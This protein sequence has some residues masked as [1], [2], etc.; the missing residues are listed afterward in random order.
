VGPVELQYQREM[1]EH[2]L[3]MDE[4][5]SDYLKVHKQ[6][7]PCHRAKMV[8]WLIEIQMNFGC[9]DEAYFLAIDLMDRYFEATSQEL[10]P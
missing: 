10:Q 6:I 1:R 8:D 5:I 3:T 7:L 9:S 2:L 4:P